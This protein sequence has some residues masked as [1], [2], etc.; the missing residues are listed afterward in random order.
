MP[1]EEIHPNVRKDVSSTDPKPHNAAPA[2]IAA[3]LLFD[4][5]GS[6]ALGLKSS[7]P[8]AGLGPSTPPSPLSC[9]I[10][11]LHTE[12]APIDAMV[13]GLFHHPLACQAEKLYTPT[14]PLSTQASDPEELVTATDLT[15]S[16]LWL[17]L[18]LDLM[19]SIP[20]DPSLP[21]GASGTSK[22]YV[23]ARQ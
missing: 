23:R 14:R 11:G 20:T 15:V 3:P 1:L 6:L 9:V 7:R 12:D 22:A 16:K 18:D 8:G 4:H 10:S 13:Q 21:Y 2:V 19:A 5:L 17:G